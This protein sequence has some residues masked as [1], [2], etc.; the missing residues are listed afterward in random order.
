MKPK[1]LAW[2]SLVSEQNVIKV[3]DD[4]MIVK[5]DNPEKDVVRETGVDLGCY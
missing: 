1:A 2:M 5:K 4:L 3:T